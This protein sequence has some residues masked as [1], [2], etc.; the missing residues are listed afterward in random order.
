MVDQT[1]QRP[2]PLLDSAVD[3]GQVMKGTAVSRWPHS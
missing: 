2:A 1:G 3:W